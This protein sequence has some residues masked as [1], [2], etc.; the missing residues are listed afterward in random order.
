MHILGAKIVDTVFILLEY[1][2]DMTT[3]KMAVMKRA[4]VRKLATYVC[5]I[6]K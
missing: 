2:M 5:I 6:A 1:V 3:V 4:V